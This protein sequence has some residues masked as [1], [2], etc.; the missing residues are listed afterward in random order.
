VAAL[1]DLPRVASALGAEP[2]WHEVDPAHWLARSRVRAGVHR[3]AMVG[4]SGAG[5]ALPW[6]AVEVAAGARAEQVASAVARRLAGGGMPGVVL[7]LSPH[8]RELAVAV[9]WEEAPALSLELDRP[10]RI[11]LASLRRMAAVEGESV[12]ARAAALAEA[13]RGSGL[14]RRFFRQFRTVLER[15]AA[16]LPGPVGA[17]ERRELALLQLT[18]VLFLYFVQCKGWLAGDEH[19]LARQV[20]R[21]LLRGRR[22]HRD[23]FLPLFFGTLNR[24]P[25][26]RSATLAF[27]AVPFLNGGLFEP[28][29]LERRW[30]VDV[31][32]A[33]W[34]DAFDLL[35]ERFHFT[36]DERAAGPV[37]APDMLGRVFEGLMAPD[38]RRARGAFY[39]P[40]HLVRRL[41]DAGLAA[42]V[43]TRLGGDADEAERRLAARDP[44]AIALLDGVAIL[45]PAVGSGAFLLGALERLAELA[46]DGESPAAPAARRRAILRRNL[47][48]VDLDP[49]AVRL[50]ELR[51]WLA[52]VADDATVDPLAVEPL[53]NLDQLVR[54]GDSL[55]EGMGGALA[56]PL[57][58]AATGAHLARLRS[59]MADATGPAKRRL[60]GELRRT[61]LAAAREALAEEERRARRGVADRLADGR[62]ATLFGERRGLDGVERAALAAARE[63]L[64]QVRRLRRELERRGA[65]PWFAYGIHFADVLARGGFDLVVGNPP[66]V[67]AEELEPG[68]RARLAARY[69]WWRSGPAG[70]GGFGHR[71]DL[72]LAFL[73]R[74]W[75]LAAPDG[76]LALLLPSKLATAG[77][78]AR[79]R[80]ALASGG[81]LHLVADLSSEAA[82]FDATVYP[83][84]L[85]A[86]RA[87]APAEHRVRAALAPDA[88]TCAQ[89]ALA[90]ARG[91]P[92]VLV[93][94]RVRD[95]VAALRGAHPRLAESRRCRLGVKT[96]A[97][98]VFLEPPADVEPALLRPALRGRDVEPFRPCPRVRLLWAHAP[99][100]RPLDRL[101]PGAHRWIERHRARLVRRA[102]YH[103]GAPWALFR[104]A[105]ACAPSVVWADVA[106]RLSALALLPGAGAPVPLNTCYVVPAASPTE[107]QALAAWLNSTWL[108]VTAR[109]EATAAA[110]GFAR[111]DARTVGA[112]PWPASMRADADLAALAR[113]GAR[114]RP[115]QDDIDALVARA[116]DL[117][118]A[119]R[120]ALRALERARADDRR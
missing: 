103:G 49:A 3:A 81:T 27:G 29:P 77:Y 56:L 8:A 48:G 100:G 69:R 13:A 82:A 39:T 97:D 51:L 21:C 115:V 85:V 119:H 94:D 19:F 79:A 72:S 70:R 111:F 86:G 52:V 84:A 117:S 50:T 6:W 59:Q 46:G 68:V 5:G 54:Q 89:S 118:A 42:L 58:T 14:D 99:D 105:A 116:L 60:A 35:F 30:K 95:A 61:E 17:S 80:Q 91:G 26:A 67:R 4:S 65:L 101:P 31:P 87:A 114:G 62:S 53:P 74:G 45:D 7:A 120:A 25:D 34:R 10:S 47:F 64:R 71:P 106:R 32:N 37:I 22:L 36:V 15:T 90:G 104:V 96:G 43:G 76:V 12:V 108:R 1:P 20:D 24:R 102:D 40:A 66:W 55:A 63:R 93:P 110:G 83:L 88:P 11:A 112:L 44:A 109:L 92:W 41:L 28:H 107:A 57:P 16:G 75:E 9:G 78:G 23:L 98:E 2:R 113:A 18:R 73:E 33:L 38:E